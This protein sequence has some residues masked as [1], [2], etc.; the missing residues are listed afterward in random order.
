MTADTAPVSAIYRSTSHDLTDS[1]REFL[2]A[3]PFAT[4]ATCNPD[5][6]IHCVPVW[7]LFDQGRLFVATWSGSRKAR[8][9]AAGGPVTVIVDD[10]DTAVWVA[11]VGTAEVLR[12]P[13]SA[14]IND[15]LRRRYMTDAGIEAL[16]PLLEQAEDATIAVTPR[17]WKAWD[18]QS[19]LLVAVEAAGI[20]LT[21]ADT[22]YRP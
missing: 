20:P 21:G 13:A 15:R 6:T 18:Y 3:Q 1:M 11:A 22:W 9:A 7:Y 12:G 14:R 2:A 8:N 4:V 19:T 10:R 5:G 17:R 16:G